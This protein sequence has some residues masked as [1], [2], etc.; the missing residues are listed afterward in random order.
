MTAEQLREWEAWQAVV[1]LWPGDINKPQ[2]DPLVKGIRYWAECLAV[3]RYHQ[4]IEEVNSALN[5]AR[6]EVGK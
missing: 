3:M 5:S 1:K 2:N 6:K 4:S